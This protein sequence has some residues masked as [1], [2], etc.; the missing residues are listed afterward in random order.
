MAGARRRPAQRKK[1]P[2]RNRGAPSRRTRTRRTATRRA[3]THRTATHRTAT[4]RTA[5]HRTATHRTATRRRGS[6]APR[7]RRAARRAPRRRAPSRSGTPRRAP[8][9]SRVKAL[10]DLAEDAQARFDEASQ[11]A[12]QAPGFEH[13]ELETVLPLGLD[14]LPAGS[15]GW[16]RRVHLPSEATGPADPNGHGTHAGWLYL[17]VRP[18]SADPLLGPPAPPPLRD[19]AWEGFVF[20]E[21]CRRIPRSVLAAES[22]SEPFAPLLRRFAMRVRAELDDAADE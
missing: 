11:H 15:V 8:G 16:A 10:F 14:R 4:H 17:V 12:S 9:P 21:E 3:A 20:L 7:V 22:D 6:K 2:R 18:R 19:R 13:L 1:A 5:T